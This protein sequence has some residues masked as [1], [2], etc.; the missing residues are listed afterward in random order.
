M[1]CREIDIPAPDP[2][3]PWLH[4]TIAA[5]GLVSMKAIACVL[6]VMHL[7]AMR[8]RWQTVTLLRAIKIIDGRLFEIIDGMVAV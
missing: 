8:V 4:S 3:A 2:Q 1:C 5:K 7:A 6:R